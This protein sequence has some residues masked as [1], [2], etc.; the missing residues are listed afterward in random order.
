M[1][2]CDYISQNDTLLEIACRG[3]YWLHQVEFFLG[4]MTK[5]VD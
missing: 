2:V 4:F 1:L 5:L 3:A